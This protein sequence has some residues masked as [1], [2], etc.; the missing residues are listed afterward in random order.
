ME[1]GNRSRGDLFGKN[2]MKYSLLT[3]ISRIVLISQS[4]R[5]RE[6]LNQMEIPVDIDVTDVDESVLPSEMPEEYA[7]RIATAKM[8]SYFRKHDYQPNVLYITADTIVVIKNTILQKPSNVTEAKAMLSLLSGKVH[9]VITGVCLF[10]NAKTS[11]FSE[12]TEVEFYPLSSAEIEW[13]VST[14]EPFDKAGGYGIQGFG[15]F[16]VRQINGCFYNVV[17]F[18]IARWLRETKKLI[19]EENHASI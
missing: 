1:Y 15:K 12:R 17:G 2:F 19:K 8:D 11:Y 7:R 14:N 16:L 6:L 9:Y 4:P 18:P 5:R 10:W 13:Y 3:Q